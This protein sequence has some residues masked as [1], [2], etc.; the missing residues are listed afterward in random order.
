MKQAQ[1]NKSGLVVKS[2]GQ[3]N[4]GSPF[5][6]FFV[7]LILDHPVLPSVIWFLRRTHILFFFLI[8]FFTIY[9]HSGY[10]GHVT[11]IT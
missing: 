10:D 1:E 6:N 11:R 5:D 8:Y 2:H 3:P 7:G 9:G 4:P